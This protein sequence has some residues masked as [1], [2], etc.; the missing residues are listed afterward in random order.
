VTRRDWLRPAWGL[1]LTLAVAAPAAGQRPEVVELRFTGGDSFTHEQLASAIESRATDC[2]NILYQLLLLCWAGVG[3]EEA[4]LNPSALQADAFRLRVYYYERG[5]RNAGIEVDTTRVG[6]D[7]VALTFRIAEGR[8]VLVSDVSVRGAPEQL[9]LDDLPIR[10]G[11]PFDAVAYEATRDTLVNRL[12]NNGFARGQV[13]VGYTIT[14]DDPYAAAVQYEVVPGTAARFGAI[15][16]D[17]TEET[18]PELVHRMLTFDEGDVYDRSALLRSQRNLYGL[19][20]YRYADIRPDL[21]EEVDSVVPVGIRVAEGNLRRVR[22]GGGLN[23]VECANVEGQWTSRNFLGG[24][25]RVTVRGRLGNLLIHQCDALV[26]DEYTDYEG[27]TGLAAVDFTQPWFFGPR[28]SIGVGLFAETRNV[29][30]VFVRIARGGYL[31]LSRSL[32]GNAALT[33]AYR[34]ERTRLETDGDLVFCVNFVACTLDQVE[35]LK[36]PHWL[37]PMTL[38]FTLDRT[39]A[40]FTP[41]RGFIVRADLEYAS[42]STG[43]DFA[44]T[45]LLGESSAYLGEPDGL[46]LAA[47]LRG[48]IGWPHQGSTG[49]GL[50]PQKRFFAGGPNSVRGFDLYR[51]GPTLLGID[52]VPWLVNGD[53][54][55]TEQTDGAACT[56]QE[57]NDGTCDVSMLDDGLFQLQPSGGEVLV[58]GNLELRFPIPV[59][60]GKMRGAAFVDAGQVWAEHGDVALGEIIA[61]PGIGLR[62]YSPIGPIRVDAAFNPRGPQALTV[63]TTEVESCLSGSP[64]CERV[65][66]RTPREFLRNTDTVSRLAQPVA[67]GSRLDEIDS[68]GDFLGRIKLHFSIG[69]A[70]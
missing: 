19:Q 14:R 17:G 65:L 58:E 53:A 48:G 46:I 66:N 3:R 34:P 24:G 21:E 28:N 29:P 61:T 16:I 5:F 31:S 11:D 23:N 50:N 44:Y 70:F 52:A 4:F 26:N 40:L 49:I 30:E 22:I 2:R 60:D 42:R 32:G 51:L 20:V 47:R 36:S 41:S 6:E 10:A 55:N 54:P 35:D 1:A 64:S 27:L 43:S 25:R 59:L 62:Y 38:S 67:Y 68:L 8:P 33:L 37:S 18:S 7:A 56:A 69:Q 39:D 15:R 9:E 45:R 57:V 63:L 12:Q 13:L